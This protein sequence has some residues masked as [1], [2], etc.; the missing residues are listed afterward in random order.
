MIV[1]TKADISAVWQEWRGLRVLSLLS[2]RGAVSVNI[3]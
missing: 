3:R 1:G 2:I